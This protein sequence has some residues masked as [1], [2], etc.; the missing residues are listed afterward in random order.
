MIYTWYMKYCVLDYV[1][2]IFTAK[3]YYKLF[4]QSLIYENNISKYFIYRKIFI[5]NKK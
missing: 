5:Q 1:H 3:L 4:V 2:H